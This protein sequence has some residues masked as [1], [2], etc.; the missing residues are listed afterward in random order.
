MSD[1]DYFERELEKLREENESQRQRIERLEEEISGQSPDR[2]KQV[3]NTQNL[4]HDEASGNS[5]EVENALKWLGRIGILAIVIGF[6]FFIKY[7]IDNNWVGYLGRIT[8]GVLSGALLVTGGQ[9]IRRFNKYIRM[10]N[11]LTSGGI[12]LTYFSVYASY[13]FEAYRKAIG[14]SWSITLA[15]LTII[16][17]AGTLISLYRDNRQILGLTIALGFIASFLSAEFQTITLAYTLILSLG[18][19]VIS[20]Y[21]DWLKTPILGLIFTY[22]IFGVWYFKN[23][24][25][26]WVNAGF[27]C[28]YAILYA[29]VTWVG[30]LRN[31]ENV[32]TE[33]IFIL[34]AV[35]FYIFCLLN[36]NSYNQEFAWLGSIVIGLSYYFSAATF[37]WIEADK[38][39][40][41]GFYIATTAV[42][43]SAPLKFDGGMITT[44]WATGA[45]IIALTASQLGGRTLRYTAYGTGILTASKILLLD[46]SQLSFTGALNV[47]LFGYLTAIFALYL[48]YILLHKEQDMI[49]EYSITV[50]FS[51]LASIG[52]ALLIELRYDGLPVSVLWALFALIILAL[53]IILNRKHLRLEGI[54]VFTVT[55]SKVFL[56]DTS[57]LDTVGRTISML[58]LGL[59]LL[60]ASFGYLKYQ[61]NLKKVI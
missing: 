9:A 60:T 56:V 48:V 55:I 4:G 17:G 32:Y 59:I 23:S 1:R 10:S 33:I 30:T 37:K 61:N 51:T 5:F 12:A 40:R 39:K 11:I 16:V 50:I 45:I 47:D 31:S 34:N 18:L 57:N 28:A 43:L 6:S 13:H 22:S 52:V 38:M 53:G 7:A 41:Y 2:K 3:Q 36:L 20:S 26:F 42:F 25:M 15:L 19:I 14:T 49:G 58:V 44:L 27:L 8:V 35:I 46:A 54:A 29:T 21:K 24:E